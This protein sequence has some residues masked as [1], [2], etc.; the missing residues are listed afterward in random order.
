MAIW[1]EGRQKKC[2]ENLIKWSFYKIIF[3]LDI[4]KN[5]WNFVNQN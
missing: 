2:L 5:D 4:N 1:P 3:H